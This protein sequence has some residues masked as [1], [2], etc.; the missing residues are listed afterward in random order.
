R[1]EPD[2]ATRLSVLG[3][4]QACTLPGC[5]RPAR[6]CEIDHG[7]PFDH[8]HPERGGRT[9]PANLH[10]LCPAHHQAKTEGRITMRRTGHDRVDWV[11]P[12]GT[13]ATAIARR[14]DDGGSLTVARAPTDTGTRRAA[15]ATIEE[16]P[17]I[18]PL[19]NR[20][21]ASAVF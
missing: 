14:V 4:W 18:D 21:A 17:V 15:S 8:D 16:R 5:S 13:T 2:R 9:E 6:E 3:A 11:P 12:L 20:R 10:P 7:I 19:T 1:Y